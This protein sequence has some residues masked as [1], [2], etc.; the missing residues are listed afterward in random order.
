MLWH[1]KDMYNTGMK[2]YVRKVIDIEKPDAVVCHNLTR[3]SISIWD[4]I[5][6][7]FRYYMIYI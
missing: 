2:E 7:A 6:A 1:L 4:E 3:F 5:K